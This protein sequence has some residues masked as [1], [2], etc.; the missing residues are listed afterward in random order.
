M[1]ELEPRCQIL[2]EYAKWTALSAV[3]RGPIRAQEPVYELLDGIAFTAVLNPSL[4]PISCEGFERW[5]RAQTKDL[6]AR[7]KPKLPRVEGH[8]SEFPVGWSAKLINVYLK[9]AAYVGDLGREGLRDVLH[10]PVD[11]RLRDR[12]AKCFRRKH[13]EICDAVRFRS[14][15]AIA[16]YED[17]QKI[18]GGCRAAAEVL[19]CSLFEIEQLWSTVRPPRRR[20]HTAQRQAPRTRPPG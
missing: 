3:R 6:C 5:H 9:T 15:N 16:T 7:A 10:P 19:G 1:D 8:C 4:E 12:L 11:N 17:Y 20:R 2:S 18:I 13:P 14:I